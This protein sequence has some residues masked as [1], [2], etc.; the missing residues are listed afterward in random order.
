MSG[1]VNAAGSP[2]FDAAG[3]FWGIALHAAMA[4]GQGAEGVQVPMSKLKAAFGESLF[5][6]VQDAA[7]AQQM[8]LDEIYERSWRTTVQ[9][10]GL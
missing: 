6:P 2:V 4:D 8:A 10:L 7:P 3:R 9:V 1:W 5:G